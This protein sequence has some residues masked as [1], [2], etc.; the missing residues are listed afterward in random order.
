MSQ[1][2][3]ILERLHLRPSFNSA[4]SLAACFSEKQPARKVSQA[5]RRK[6]AAR[7]RIEAHQERIAIA[8]SLGCSPQELGEL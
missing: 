2:Y 4:I 1:H 5:Q 6:A 7:R 8:Q 3:E